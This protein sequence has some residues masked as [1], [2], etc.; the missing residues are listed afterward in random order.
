MSSDALPIIPIAAFL[1]AAGCYHLVAPA[2]AENL[3]SRPGPVRVVG[4]ILSL[5]G[6]WCF[7]FPA[8]ATHLV[9]FPILLSGVVRLLAPDRMITLNTWTSRHTH[10]ALM[11][12]GAI[13]CLWLVF[14]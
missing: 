10:G 2:H 3:L 1:A 6:A 14:A 12:L 11:L 8:I 7:V 5:L 4:A 13:G 9:G